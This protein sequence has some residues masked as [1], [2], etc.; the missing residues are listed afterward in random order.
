M[1][2]RAKRIF[3]IIKS[4][5]EEELRQHLEKY[6]DSVKLKKHVTLPD[7]FHHSECPVMFHAAFYQRID[8][9]PILKDAGADIDAVDA[10]NRSALYIVIKHHN[11]GEKSYKDTIRFLAEMGAST[12]LRNGKNAEDF[13]QSPKIKKN[14]N[15]EY[16]EPVDESTTRDTFIYENNHMV[17]FTEKGEATSITIKTIFNFAQK[18]II[19]L[20]KD[21]DGQCAVKES[22]KNAS[23]PQTLQNAATF[24][25]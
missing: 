9:L 13:A 22:F 15:P 4:G 6:P 24:L 5:T 8:M 17:S 7:G 25:S 11:D 12:T 1:F 3:K 19:T 2:N 21:K 20:I 23:N 10:S 18:N 16:I 14:F